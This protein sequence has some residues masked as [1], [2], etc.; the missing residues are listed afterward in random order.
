M[1]LMWALSVDMYPICVD[2][3]SGRRHPVVRLDWSL[4]KLFLLFFVNQLLPTSGFCQPSTIVGNYHEK[5]SSFNCIETF[6]LGD[7][8]EEGD[9]NLAP[10]LMSP[11]SDIDQLQNS[12]SIY[13]SFWQRFI[14]ETNNHLCKVGPWLTGGW[15]RWWLVERHVPW[16]L[17][18]T[19]LRGHPLAGNRLFWICWSQNSDS[20]QNLNI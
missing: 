16:L 14:K 11:L 19:Y 7:V 18:P 2:P 15:H 17:P 5:S 20:L 4:G 9:N 12:R 6:R 8:S 3:R 13:W 1:W 10:Y